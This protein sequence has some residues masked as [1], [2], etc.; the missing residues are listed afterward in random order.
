MNSRRLLRIHEVAELLR[1][2]VGSI[3]H[4][5][6]Q[7]RIP[8]IRISTRCIRFDPEEV[9][10]WIESMR[11]ENWHDRRDRSQYL[12]G[13]E[14]IDATTSEGAAK[15]GVFDYQIAGSKAEAIK[16]R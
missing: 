16:D 3:Y 8:V 4:L 6:S 7:K 1:M 13:K 9:Q 14:N 12:R 15:E 11:Q 5:V 2:S 10:R